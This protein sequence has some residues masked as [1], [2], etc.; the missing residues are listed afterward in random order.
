MFTDDG[1]LVGQVAKKGSTRRQVSVLSSWME[2]WNILH[3]DCAQTALELVKYQH[4]ICQLFTPDSSSLEV[5]QLFWQAAAMDKLHNLRW[6]VLKEDVLVWVSHISP[7]MH[8]NSQ[9]QAG[10][11]PHQ[12][13]LLH[14]LVHTERATH[15]CWV[16][17]CG[18]E[19][20]AKAWPCAA[21]VAP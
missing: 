14:H 9:F 7:F 19:H 5:W 6:D 8:G 1:L 2:A 18:G 15:R 3:S 16:P 17:G 20:S 12:Q 4:I 11:L 13:A 10:S 21:P